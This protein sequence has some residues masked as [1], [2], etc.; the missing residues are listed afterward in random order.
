M[1]KAKPMSSVHHTA[2]SL[3]SGSEDEHS[4][5]GDAAADAA[6]ANSRGRFGHGLLRRR[7][8]WVSL[9]LLLVAATAAI[10]VPL[11]YLIVEPG[12][13]R[14]TES[15]VHVEGPHGFVDSGSILFLTISEERATVAT[16]I[17]AYLDDN[18]DI[19]P[20]AKRRPQGDRQDEIVN[21]ARMDDSKYTAISLALHA[22]G[23]PVT[24]TGTGAFIA[25]VQPGFPAAA[26]LHQG[27]VITAVDATAVTT[28]PQLGEALAGKPVGTAVQLAVRSPV[29]E[30]RSVATT[31][32]ERTQDPSRGYLGV[33]VQTA[34]RSLDSPAKI[35]ID[36]GSV[37]GPSAGLAFTL[38]VI[39][40]LTP[41]SLTGGA[42]VAVTGA[43]SPDGSVQAIGGI[44]QKA[45]T[46]KDAGATRFIYP[47][48]QTPAE[49]KRVHEILG[50]GVT[51]SPVDS[52]AEAIKV[53]A[54]NG[55]PPVPAN[56]Q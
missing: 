54:P 37:L 21:K 42:K 29:G 27:D 35:S 23:I 28:S 45:V 4:A 33:T 19:E 38:A 9:L 30:T 7:W 32:G 56:G 46:V 18:I 48:S 17:R 25:A 50:N 15:R 49:I 3:P 47:R 39:D 8:P 41:G 20:E 16:A 6:G 11:P 43:I 14:A 10:T 44:E 1:T 13:A 36:S 22:V 5:A 40:R 55:L 34:D 52:L 53:L 26:V 2:G 24:E 31:L 51:L 12:S